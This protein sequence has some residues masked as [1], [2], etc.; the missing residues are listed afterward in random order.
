MP[1]TVEDLHDRVVVVNDAL[2]FT[3]KLHEGR[4][5]IGRA[6]GEAIPVIANATAQAVYRSGSR[7]LA[8]R[9]DDTGTIVWTGAKGQDTHGTGYHALFYWTG[10]N[11]RL[12]LTVVMYDNLPFMLLRLTFTHRE[13]SS[14]VVESLS[15]V[16]V[17]PRQDG[18]LRLSDV[19]SSLVSFLN[20]WSSCSPA[21]C[22][23]AQ[24]AFSSAQLPRAAHWAYLNAASPTGSR[25]ELW[26][27]GFTVIGPPEGAVPGTRHGLVAGYVSQAD[28]FA[29]VGGEYPSVEA[30]EEP[31]NSFRMLCQCDATALEPNTSLASEW[32]YLQWVDLAEND[33]LADYALA[34]AR[35]MGARIPQRGPVGWSSGPQSGGLADEAT[36]CA[37]LDAIA[38]TR[39]R[40]PVELVLVESGYADLPGDWMQVNSTRFPHG[41]AWLTD[42]IRAQGLIPGLWLAP[43]VVHPESLVAADQPEWLLKD[44]NGRPVPGGIIGKAQVYALDTT[45][46]G[47]IQWLAELIRRVRREWGFPFLKLDYLYAAAL[48]GQ[49]H[50]MRLTRAQALQQALLRVREAAGQDT[51]LLGAACPL[52]PAVGVVNALRVGPDGSPG[53]LVRGGSWAGLRPG[54]ASPGAR[55]AMRNALTRSTVHRRWWLNDP[56]CIVLGTIG[57][58]ENDL[59]EA[60]ACS[61]ASVIG[62]SGGLLTFGDDLPELDPARLKLLEPLQ[63]ALQ[64][65]ATAYDLLE[66]EMPERFVLRMRR[67]CGEWAV[68]GVFNW[69]DTPRDVAVHLREMGLV[70]S[71]ARHVADQYGTVVETVYDPDPAASLPRHVYDFWNRRYHRLHGA[72]LLLPGVPAHGCHVLGIRRM[73]PG[74]HLVATS[75]HLSQGGEIGTWTVEP[76]RLSFTVALGHRAEGEVLLWTERPIRAARAEGKPVEIVQVGPGV[77]ALRFAVAKVAKVEVL[78]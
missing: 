21:G 58:R 11:L 23:R 54:P 4:F 56:D 19:P 75:F 68:V 67:A 43:F 2:S 1:F 72:Q 55:N 66:H 31:P 62:L 32:A 41:M 16:V 27:E 7:S 60:E 51:F 24:E 25:S 52:G 13:S 42:Q 33:S 5:T 47:V 35:Q 28:Q 76:G 38:R 14:L 6:G 74:P 50:D 3:F 15:P 48:P 59:T 46:P 26:S 39:D 57:A 71:R 44:S 53:W 65:S 29:I 37:G 18:S 30:G 49:R 40:L 22:S 36:I 20:G 64:E 9:M 8:V 77:S 34:A 17:E 73:Q 78:L 70:R 63:P 45:H 61:V 12:G 10:E 69:S